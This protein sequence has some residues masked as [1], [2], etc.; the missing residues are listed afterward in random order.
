MELKKCWGERKIKYKK[1]NT[2][3]IYK[4]GAKEMLNAKERLNI[5]T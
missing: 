1:K 3:I 4:N 2:R 5:K